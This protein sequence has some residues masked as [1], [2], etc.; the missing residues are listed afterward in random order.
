MHPT[1]QF[2]T[3]ISDEDQFCPHST[4][5]I[6][7]T[8]EAQSMAGGVRESKSPESSPEPTNNQGGGGEWAS[9]SASDSAANAV[10]PSLKT[11]SSSRLDQSSRP[12]L[13]SVSRSNFLGQGLLSQPSVRFRKTINTSLGAGGHKVAVNAQN[14]VVLVTDVNQDPLRPGRR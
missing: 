4:F 12:L 5:L 3:L 14:Y 2:G 13:A 9:A 10:L 6:R 11:R 8:R 1:G 7:Y